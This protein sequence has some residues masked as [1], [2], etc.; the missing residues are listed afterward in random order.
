MHLETKRLILR[1]PE[2][3]DVN[4]YL[5]FCNSTFV[6]RYNAMTP[7]DAAGVLR[8]ISRS[9][10]GS[11]LVLQ[12]KEDG[13]VFGEICIQEDSLRYGVDSRELS[14]LLAEPY[15]RQG[16][17]KEALQAVIDYLFETEKVECVSA[18]CFAPNEASLA[19]LKSLGF[20]KDGY[21]PRCVKGYAGRIFDDTLHSLFR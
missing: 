5:E 6:L 18:R 2:E 13:K 17:M 16:Y 20:R 7:K 14:Y 12:S 8:W 15:S 4:D 19:L 21:I 9:Q 1:K 11:V 3:K 10:D